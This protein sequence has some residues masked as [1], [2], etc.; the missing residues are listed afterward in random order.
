[1]SLSLED[2]RR[3]L[4]GP[5]MSTPSGLGIGHKTLAEHGAVCPAGTAV[6]PDASGDDFCFGTPLPSTGIVVVEAPPAVFL[7]DGSHHFGSH[8]GSHPHGGPPHAAG[9]GAPADE[10]QMFRANNEGARRAYASGDTFNGDRFLAAA[11]EL[12][13]GSA[14]VQNQTGGEL[15]GTQQIRD[16]AAARSAYQ[17]EQAAAPSVAANA[18]PDTIAFTDD[19]LAALY[20][21]GYDPVT[22]ASG[23]FVNT[24]QAAAEMRS[25][26]LP[27]FVDAAA[28]Q[29]GRD[30]TTKPPLDL[31]AA[32]NESLAI[33]AAIGAS[34]GAALGGAVSGSA[35]GTLGGGVGGAILGALLGHFIKSAPAP[36][37]KR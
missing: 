24:E 23:G 37:A 4:A 8:H 19:P 15:A 34:V 14:F 28:P 16:D 18:A 9:H 25:T 2:L 1:M 35:G 7:G 21:R 27:P 6:G 30:L 11:Q 31:S 10:L 17:A 26:G 3:A 20:F 22:L 32:G 12:Y 13:D 5:V 36:G 33:G 29:S